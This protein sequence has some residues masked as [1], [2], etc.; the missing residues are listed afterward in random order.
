MTDEP[1]AWAP[2]K[3]AADLG[4]F[5]RDAREKAD[6]SQEAVADELGID[7]RYIYQIEAGTPTLYTARLFALLRLLDVRMEVHQ[8]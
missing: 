1:K 8:R 6:L 5:L 3:S 2:V 4:A 7:R